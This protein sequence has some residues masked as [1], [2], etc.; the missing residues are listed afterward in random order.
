MSSVSV[1]KEITIKLE[2][3]EREVLEKAHEILKTLRQD[4]FIREDDSD[5]YY[6]V[7][8]AATSLRCTL[9]LAGVFV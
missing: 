1:S 9:D 3:E 2:S 6:I 7:D 8:A 5:E 4:L